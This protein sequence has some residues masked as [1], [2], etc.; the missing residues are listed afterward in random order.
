MITIENCLL[1]KMFARINYYLNYLH[2]YKLAC[3]FFLSTDVIG[4]K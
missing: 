4:T 3:V 2:H 1:F